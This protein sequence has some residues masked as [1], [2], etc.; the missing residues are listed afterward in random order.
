M[1]KAD[2]KILTAQDIDIPGFICG[3]LY[4]LDPGYEVSRV[5]RDKY[6]RLVMRVKINGQDCLVKAVRGLTLW[7]RPGRY[8]RFQKEIF[9]YR[10]LDRLDFEY[11]HFPGLLHTDGKSIL[12]TEFIENDPS[13]PLD[14]DFYES[15]LKAVVE[16]NTCDFPFTEK[17][18]VGWLWEKINRWKFSRSTKTMRHLLE[19]FFITR[20]VSLVLFVQA[21]LFWVRAIKDSVK[22]K[23]PLLV[24]RDIFGSN[25]LRPGPERICFIDF[26]KAGIEKRW[27]FVDALKISLARHWFSSGEK[28]DPNDDIKVFPGLCPRLLETYWRKLL[29]GHPEINSERK[30]FILQLRFCL[31]SWALSKLVK[32]GTRPEHKTALSRFIRE[33]L[34][35]READFEKWFKTSNI[36]DRND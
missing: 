30:Q 24:H 22:L 17:G 31:L 27:V 35:G 36:A 1:K 4:S 2:K 26:E 16:L 29:P 7:R 6:P 12:V 8:F 21:M 34:L 25:I 9:I 32:A 18:G 13:L 14:R 15:A 20:Q 33:T 10:Q 19:G 11:F 23:K 28:T 3:Y 5:I